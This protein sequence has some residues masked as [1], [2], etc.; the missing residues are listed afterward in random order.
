MDEDKQAI[1]RQFGATA[2][3]Y[4]SSP[5]HATGPDLERIVALAGEMEQREQALDIATGGGH[6][7]RMIAPLFQR[8]VI[9]DLTEPMLRAA[10]GFLHQQGLSTPNPVQ[11]D[12]EQLP[13]ATASFDLVTCRIAPHHFPNPARFVREVTRVLRPGG[14]FI[15]ADS[16]VPKSSEGAEWLNHLETCRDP[17]HHRTLSV[18]E[19]SNLVL[20]S[21]LLI[22]GHDLF[23]KRHNLAE[24]LARARTPAAQQSAV[25]AACTTASPEIRKAFRLE[26]DDEGIPVAFT[27]FKLLLW[28]DKR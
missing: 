24:W 26:Y 18:A 15:L 10:T 9:S 19:W 13:F 28:A 23:P 16:T 27:D 22:R 17:T 1:Q 2:S 5:G 6:T 14:R 8:I 12:A 4:V 20:D 11:A 21:R 25:L 3:A 7:A